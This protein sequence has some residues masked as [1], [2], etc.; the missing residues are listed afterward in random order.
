VLKVKDCIIGEIVTAKRGTTLKKVIR[1]FRDNKFHNLPVVDDSG[2]LVGKVTLDEIISVF[3]PQS[4]EI[5][6]LLKTIPFLDTVPEVD[7]DIDYI[8]PEMGILIVA[9]EIMTKNYFTVHPE[10][11]IAKAYSVMK[12]NNTRLLMVIDDEGVLAGVLG[13]FDIMYTMFARKGVVD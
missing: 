3:Q 8:T 7:I 13:M 5:N 1:L 4:S 12:A 9:D 10:D 2:K 6:Q 11:T